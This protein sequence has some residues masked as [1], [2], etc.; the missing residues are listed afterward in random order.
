MQ[1]YEVIQKHQL[2][3][4]EEE[5]RINDSF[6]ENALKVMK[7]RYLLRD[8]N[9]NLL[10]SPIQML[11]RMAHALAEVEKQYGKNQYEIEQIEKDFFYIM[12]NK[13]FTPAGRTITNAGA[14]SPLVAN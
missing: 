1:Y 11:H 6:S 12:A 3:S 7:K 2:V 4:A 5:K 13:Q 14:P 9:G 8:E 10:E